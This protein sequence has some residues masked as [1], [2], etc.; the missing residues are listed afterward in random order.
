MRIYD[1]IAKLAR[2]IKKRSYSVIII[3][4]PGCLIVDSVINSNFDSKA[5]RFLGH[6]PIIYPTCLDLYAYANGDLFNFRDLSGR[7]A[8]CSYDV[9]NSCVIGTGNIFD[10]TASVN[11]AGPSQS[12][13]PSHHQPKKLLD[14]LMRLAREAFMPREFE[15]TRTLK[16]YMKEE[17]ARFGNFDKAATKDPR[18][19]STVQRKSR[20][21]DQ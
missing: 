8:S 10:F 14:V 20:E 5:G 7:F 15:L 2:K 9:L 18:V 16:V 6:D 3:A 13:A 21:I 12:S 17:I 19:N 11:G 1:V 4:F